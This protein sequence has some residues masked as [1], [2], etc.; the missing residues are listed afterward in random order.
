MKDEHFFDASAIIALCSR[1]KADKPLEGW[2]LNP[3]L[4]EVGNAVWKQVYLYKTFT[5]EEGNKALDALTEVIKKMMRTSIDDSL[6]ILKIA[7]TEG[8]TYYDAAY[9]HATLKNDKT[10]VTNDEKLYTIAKKYVK[11]IK[12]NKL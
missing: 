6:D 4:Y 5:L 1:G 12:N 8:L 3:A 10:L 7:V 2:T 9:L 11:T